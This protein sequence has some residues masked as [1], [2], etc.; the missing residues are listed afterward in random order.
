MGM[1]GKRRTRAVG[2]AIL[3]VAIVSAA[4]KE[5]VY[6]IL[7]TNKTSTMEKELNEAAANG[8]VFSQVMG[9]DT[10]GGH[11]AVV[12]MVK[13]SGAKRTYKLLATNKTSTMQKELQAIADE[14]FDY[15]GQTVY[16]SSFGGREVIVIMEKVSGAKAHRSTY[17]LQATTKTS[18]MEKEL[19]VDGA[20]GF[21]LVGMTVGKTALGGNEIVSILRKD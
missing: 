21:Y 17:R 14:G 13:G 11:E 9:G 20:D 4:D 10:V 6:K 15:L 7:A 8:W 12:A 19:N 18:T 16:Q 3:T 5:Y 2:L 1:F